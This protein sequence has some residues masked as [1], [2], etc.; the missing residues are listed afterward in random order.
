MKQRLKLNEFL[1]RSANPK[2]KSEIYA[3]IKQELMREKI[4]R[5]ETRREYGIKTKH[6]I[7]KIKT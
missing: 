5:K 4:K 1:P 6:D 7:K 2:H 3:S